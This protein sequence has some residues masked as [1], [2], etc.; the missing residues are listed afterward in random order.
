MSQIEPL[1]R[2]TGLRPL[3]VR[4][5]IRAMFTQKLVAGDR[6]VVSKL[7]TQLGASSTPVR[8]ALLE[9][10]TLG[11]VEL[12]PNRGAV[13]LPFGAEELREMY[14]VRRVLEVE[15]TRRATGNLAG[16]D[17]HRAKLR[18][19]LA[20][21]GA[22]LQGDDS[23]QGW[24]HDAVRVDVALHDLIAENC[25]SPRLCHE[26]GRYKELMVCVRE[27]VRNERSVQQIAMEEHVAI[28]EHLLA[29]QADQ[30]AGAMSRHLEHTASLVAALLFP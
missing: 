13:C 16:S 9:L 24:L 27:I 6:L 3:V 2:D 1:P 17:A 15:A 20:T 21:L 26:I 8:E 7:A 29:D 22:L 5:L 19:I 25:A 4:Q 14:L 10:N 11:L 23:V 18:E 12:I 28:V 30:A